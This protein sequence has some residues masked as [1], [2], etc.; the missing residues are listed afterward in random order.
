MMEIFLIVSLIF[1]VLLNLNQK[2]FQNLFRIRKKI[3]L[4][5]DSFSTNAVLKFNSSAWETKN[6]LHP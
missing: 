5:N 1:K 6:L 4:N 3:Y 2:R